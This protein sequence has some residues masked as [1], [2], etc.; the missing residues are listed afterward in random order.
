[1]KV[2]LSEGPLSVRSDEE[3]LQA[4]GRDPQA[5]DELYRRHV[6]KI[7]SFAVHRCSSADEIPDLVAAVWLEVIVSADRFDRRRGNA[8]PWVLGIAA[9]LHA[10]ETRRRARQQEAARRLAGQRILDEDDYARLER[11]IESAAVAPVLREG[12]ARLP[13]GERAVMEL[14]ALDG[15]TPAEAAEALGIL[16]A[17]A[18]MRL[19]RARRKLREDL[20]DRSDERTQ[21]MGF[22]EVIP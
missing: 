2:S 8:V 4:A 22:E 11:Q 12:L 20:I 3:L 5:F 6:E 14:V 10:S 18:R 15:L 7:V 17:A 9:N 16:P 1:V 19:A 13:A 21:L